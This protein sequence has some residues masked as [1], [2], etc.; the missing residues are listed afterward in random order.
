MIVDGKLF[1]GAHG[2]GAELGHSI[3]VVNGRPCAA[4]EL[5]SIESY[6]SATSIVKEAVRRVVEEG[7]EASWAEAARD[8]TLTARMLFDAMEAGD[9]LAESVIDEACM[10]LGASCV[11]MARY[12]DPQMIVLGGGVAAAGDALVSR[13]TKWFHELTWH[14]RKE[15]AVVKAAELGNDAGF[16]GAAVLARERF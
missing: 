9:E 10:Y 6:C 2:A 1:T 15:R 12:F 16:I 8:G 4:G 3:I 14:V 7:K 13:V 11:N 5:G